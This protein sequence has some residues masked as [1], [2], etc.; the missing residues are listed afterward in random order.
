MT[1]TQKLGTIDPDKWDTYIRESF[2]YLQEIKDLR[3]E[4]STLINPTANT[5][6]DIRI[7]FTNLAMGLTEYMENVAICEAFWETE[8]HKSKKESYMKAKKEFSTATVAA[9]LYKGYEPY[10]SVFE[11]YR[12]LKRSLDIINKTIEQVNAICNS[13]AVKTKNA[14]SA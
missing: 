10:L 14:Y 5:L 8:L 7:Q 13:L 6:A 2:V 3:E 9:T 4:W 11:I 1:P 12:I